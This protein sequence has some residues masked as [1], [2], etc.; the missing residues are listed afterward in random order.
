M[1]KNVNFGEMY[2]FV[3]LE[4]VSMVFTKS[5]VGSVHLG[6]MYTFVYLGERV[7]AVKTYLIFAT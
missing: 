1:Y 7:L 6:K 4:N 2:I 3:H 5:Y